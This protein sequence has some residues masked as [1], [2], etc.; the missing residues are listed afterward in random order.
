M[1]KGDRVEI[2][3]KS[4][5]QG[6]TMRWTEVK[7]GEKK[8][9]A[10][11]IWYHVSDDKMKYFYP[12]ETC[13]GD[14]K[15]SE[16]HYYALKIIN[17]ITVTCYG[18]DEIRVDLDFHKNNVEIIYIG[19]VKKIKTGRSI[20]KGVYGFLPEYKEIDNTIRI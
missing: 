6:Q 1:K 10:G 2:S 4:K 13:F 12:K 9:N 8:I 11:D 17:P 19:T 15:Y 5:Y 7:T 14:K 18:Y 20:Y 3:V 16:G